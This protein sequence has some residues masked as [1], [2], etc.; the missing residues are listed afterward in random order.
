MA[1]NETL[2]KQS[3][4]DWTHLLAMTKNKDLLDD[5]FSIW[6]EAFETARILE[7]IDCQA[8]IQTA[9]VIPD[10]EG[11]D[12][13]KITIKE[14]KD[15]QRELIEKIIDALQNKKAEMFQFQEAN[16]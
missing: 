3:F 8:I 11:D 13:K 12:T 5:P 2:I 4:D 1:A 15:Q 10:V 6:Y 9:F 7:R 16:N 14:A